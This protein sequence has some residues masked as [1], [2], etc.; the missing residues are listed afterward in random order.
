MSN[1][2]ALGSIMAIHLAAVISPGPNFLVV[3]QTSVRDSRRAGLLSASGVALAA[4]VWS[5]AALVGV[6]LLFEKAAWLYSGLKLLGGAY[7]V[8]LGVQSWR[9]AGVPL[10]ARAGVPETQASPWRTVRTGFVTNLT[11]PKSAVF[12][13]SI[14]AAL[15]S[16][17]LPFWVRGAAVGVVFFNALCWYGFVATVFSTQ[18]VQRLYVRAKRHLD[19]IV[20]GFFALLGLRLMLSSR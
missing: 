6:S 2:T 14:F 3:S 8:Y 18:R 16:P 12:F 17:S 5:L 4:V 1:F 19:R 9:H 15:L 10:E 11:N 13:G 7:L 20:G